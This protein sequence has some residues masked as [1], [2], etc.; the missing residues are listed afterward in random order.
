ML[1]LGI[2]IDTLSAAL[3]SILEPVEK[4]YTGYGSY[5]ER[6]I[7]TRGWVLPCRTALLADFNEAG[8]VGHLWVVNEPPDS[9]NIEQF[10]QA[11]TAL[12]IFGDFF[13]A[14]WNLSIA[15]PCAD[16][17]MLRRYLSGTIEGGV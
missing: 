15:V 4:I 5:Q 12:S 1:S 11:L 14:D 8:I 2:P 7:N 6:C 17:E 16:D 3:D 9:E 13:I 10:R